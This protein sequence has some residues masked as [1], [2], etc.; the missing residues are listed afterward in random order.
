MPDR[1]GIEHLGNGQA[2]C[3]TCGERFY[4]WQ[5]EIVERHRGRCGRRYRRLYGVRR[6]PNVDEQ[7]VAAAIAKATGEAA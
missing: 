3:A 5:D 2:G 1:D 6:G 7:K 4:R